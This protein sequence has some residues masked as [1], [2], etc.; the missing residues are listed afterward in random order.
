MILYVK[1]FTTYR[2]VPVII[3][4]Y[5]LNCCRSSGSLSETF[6]LY[7]HTLPYINVII[8]TISYF[9]F[10]CGFF[11]EKTNPKFFLA[12]YLDPASLLLKKY[13]QLGFSYKDFAICASNLLRIRLEI[14][15][16]WELRQ[17][18]SFIVMIRTVLKCSL[19]SVQNQ[20]FAFT[21]SPGF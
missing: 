17:I 21:M 12:W 7:I 19:I 13:I 2:T 8:T 16:V 20:L 18:H 4:C 11:F 1:E 10:C 5:L 15:F 9:F 6:I 14:K 3:H